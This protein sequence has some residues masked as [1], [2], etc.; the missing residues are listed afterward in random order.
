MSLMWVL[1][2]LDDL[3]ADFRVYYR[4]DGIGDEDF[5]DLTGPRFFALAS[6]LPL[7]GG[8]VT[9]MARRQFEALDLEGAVDTPPA[10]S[11]VELQTNPVLAGVIDYN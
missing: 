5:G 7:Y 2:N 8:A 4:I 3:D 1:D 6:R 10:S 11:A 9:A